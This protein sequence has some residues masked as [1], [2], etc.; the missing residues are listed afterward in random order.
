MLKVNKSPQKTET[1][2]E[3]LHYQVLCVYPSSSVPQSSIIV[4]YIERWT[5]FGVFVGSG[6]VVA[7]ITK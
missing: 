3:C 4:H 6:E 5:G 2:N 1:N 7:K